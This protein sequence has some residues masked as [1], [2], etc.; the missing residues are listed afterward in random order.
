MTYWKSTELRIQ[1]GQQVALSFAEGIFLPGS[2]ASSLLA[3]A[4]GRKNTIRRQPNEAT[5]VMQ[6]RGG[7]APASQR[8]TGIIQVGQQ[9]ALSFAEGICFFW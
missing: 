3:K 1:V 9:V 7:S 8:V 5:W 2:G 6:M 4:D